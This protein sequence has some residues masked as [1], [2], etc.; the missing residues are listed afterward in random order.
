MC[1]QCIIYVLYKLFMN[2]LYIICIS[3]FPKNIFFLF[4]LFPIIYSKHKII[5]IIIIIY[6]R[7]KNIYK[8]KYI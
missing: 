4:I 2:Y 1:R 6:L 5:N 3:E 8:N 7:K